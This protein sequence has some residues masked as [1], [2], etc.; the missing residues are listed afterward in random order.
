MMTGM[1]SG[2]RSTPGFLL[3]RINADVLR[4]KSHFGECLLA[5][6]AGEEFFQLAC[7]LLADFGLV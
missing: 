6:V 5:E 4:E 7:R 2:S 1:T 3:I